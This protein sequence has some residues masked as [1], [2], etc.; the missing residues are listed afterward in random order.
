[1]KNNNNMEMKTAKAI[2][3]N[4][5]EENAIVLFWIGNKIKPHKKFS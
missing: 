3:A 4:A 2:Y 5:I 1:M